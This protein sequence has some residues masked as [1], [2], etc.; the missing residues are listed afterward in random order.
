[1][2]INFLALLAGI[3]VIA[4]GCVNTVTDQHAFASTWGQDTITARYPRTGDQVYAAATK[5]VAQ[6][7]TLKLEYI[8]P[9]TNYC[10]SLQAKVSQRDVWVRVTEVNPQTAQVEVEARDDWGRSD[11]SL[12]SQL[13][14]EIALQLQQAR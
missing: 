4:A 3:A 7:G 5:V 12:A 14:T 10:R 9:G 13:S 1:M 2:K 8:T 11:V 6:N